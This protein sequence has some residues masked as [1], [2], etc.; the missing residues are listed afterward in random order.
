MRGAAGS[1]TQ[2]EMLRAYQ[3]FHVVSDQGNPLSPPRPFNLM[4]ATQIGPSG[5]APA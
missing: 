4:F 5:D 2:E 3:Q 1:Y